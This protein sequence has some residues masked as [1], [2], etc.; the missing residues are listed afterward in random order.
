MTPQKS[1]PSEVSCWTPPGPIEVKRF[2]PAKYAWRMESHPPLPNDNFRQRS[3]ESNNEEYVDSEA[4]SAQASRREVMLVHNVYGD[5]Q[6]YERELARER[7]SKTSRSA[8]EELAIP[9]QPRKHLV[10]HQ[11]PLSRPVDPV[12]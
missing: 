1:L 10:T 3:I 9:I 12:K 8:I 4:E 11:Q 7:N 5:V 2:G 6:E